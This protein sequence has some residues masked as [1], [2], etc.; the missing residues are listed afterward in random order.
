MYAGGKI[1][2]VSSFEQAKIDITSA[3][4]ALQ[5]K[6]TVSTGPFKENFRYTHKVY[7]TR[8]SDDDHTH[9]FH[10]YPGLTFYMPG[11]QGY[12]GAENSSDEM[13]K[14]KSHYVANSSGGSG[15][16]GGGGGGDGY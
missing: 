10:E 14:A 4:G 13:F 12:H 6:G 15:G 2:K 5:I 3:S 16:S 11:S 7:L 8:Q 9:T 1:V